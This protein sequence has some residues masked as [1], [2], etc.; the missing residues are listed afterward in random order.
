MRGLQQI[1]APSGEY[2]AACLSSLDFKST[3]TASLAA[4][5]LML[6]GEKVDIIVIACPEG[7]G[8]RTLAAL[9]EGRL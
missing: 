5:G 3:S 8:A 1:G 9:E 2:K 7:A 6:A 4:G